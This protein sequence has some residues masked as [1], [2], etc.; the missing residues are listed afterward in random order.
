VRA[1]AARKDG[2]ALVDYDDLIG[3]T[4]RLLVDPGLEAQHAQVRRYIAAL[5]HAGM[6]VFVRNMGHSRLRTGSFSLCLKNETTS[7]C[8]RNETGFLLTEMKRAEPG[9]APPGF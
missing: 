1:Y 8:L 3:R 2:A 7:L 4:S 9:L 5:N 6:K